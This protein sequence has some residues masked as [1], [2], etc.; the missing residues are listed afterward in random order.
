[1]NFNFFTHTIVYFNLLISCCLSNYL[2][3][4]TCFS[5]IDSSESKIKAINDII[6]NKTVFLLGEDHRAS[7][8]H[9]YIENFKKINSIKKINTVILE[10]DA[11]W[12]AQFNEYINPKYSGNYSELLEWR[13]FNSSNKDLIE[14][15][16]FLK[17]ENS[18]RQNDGLIKI[19]CIDIPYSTGHSTYILEQIIKTTKLDMN[20]SLNYNIEHLMSKLNK[21]HHSKNVKKLAKKVLKS[22]TDSALL[23][24]NIL[25]EK[26]NDFTNIV[27]NLTLEPAKGL[28]LK[29][30]L[31]EREYILFN[32]VVDLLDDSS[33]TF[34][35]I[36]GKFHVL[37]NKI[38]AYR[39]PTL[40][41]LLNERLPNKTLSILF[42]YKS[43]ISDLEKDIIS[44]SKIK[45]LKESSRSCFVAS[46]INEENYQ[47]SSFVDLIYISH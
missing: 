36:F 23:Y 38:P 46:E 22:L 5:I 27:S 14:F 33:S 39:N 3:A 10:D 24:S 32:R 1:M 2:H 26:Y 15:L 7:N 31:I 9:T 40:G 44:P 43:Y 19:K 37:K 42:F 35:I 13:E 25:N 34:F 28:N 16:F 29:R 6:K 17:E 12:E 41:N 11:S 18:Q 30:K 20:N 8:Y 4:F 45:T 47:T 21:R